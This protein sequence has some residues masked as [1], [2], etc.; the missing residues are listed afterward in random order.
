MEL[1]ELIGQ[2]AA[3]IGL[4]LLA[5]DKN[6]CFNFE[7]D[8]MPVSISGTDDG[9]VVLQGLIGEPPPDAPAGRE[10]L[11]R[12]LLE[13]MFRGEGSG[14]ATFSIDKGSGLIFLHMVEN[15]QT[16]DLVSFKALLEKFVNVLEQWRTVVAEFGFVA[17]RVDS[18]LREESESLRKMTVGIDGFIR[19]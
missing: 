3:E 19:I 2:F 4:E 15:E 13:A 6:G 9:H 8:D 14:G 17:G 12:V 18:D 16:L 5:A 11:Y 10:R 7:I 1:K